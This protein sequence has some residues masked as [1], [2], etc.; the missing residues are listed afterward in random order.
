QPRQIS[1]LRDGAAQSWQLCGSNVRRP[2]CTINAL[3]FTPLLRK[4]DNIGAIPK[5]SGIVT[6][7]TPGPMDTAARP[8]ASAGKTAERLT[9]AAVEA[10]FELPFND[11]LFR[12]QEV[13]RAQHPANAVQLSTLLSIKTGG[14]PEDCGYCPQAARYHTGVDNQAMLALDDVVE[15]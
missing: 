10:L 6:K 5:D 15:K 9:V 4:F 13:H 14:C 1:A 12:A 11:L 7:A 2:A 3:L 8:P